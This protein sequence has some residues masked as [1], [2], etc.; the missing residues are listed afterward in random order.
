MNN[1]VSTPEGKAFNVSQFY[2]T[3][4]NSIHLI[5]TVSLVYAAIMKTNTLKTKPWQH[6]TFSCLSHPTQQP[7]S[8]TQV[9]A[10]SMIILKLINAAFVYTQK[11]IG[12]V[13]AHTLSSNVTIFFS[14]NTIYYL[15]HIGLDLAAITMS[16]TNNTA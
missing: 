12:V 16:E 6:S 14:A 7:A 11:Q 4:K 13:M 9:K 1:I 15:S 8:P 3:G 10:C 2:T 5:Q